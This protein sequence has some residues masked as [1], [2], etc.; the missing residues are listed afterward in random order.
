V[1]AGN[2]P[3]SGWTVGWTFTNGEQVAQLWNATYSTAGSTVTA[4]NTTYN[5]G[6]AA[7]ASTS[8]GYTGSGTPKA[9]T[10]TCT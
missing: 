2:A 5:G 1:T 7:H 4:R 10:P 9:V 6:L 8:F 3:I